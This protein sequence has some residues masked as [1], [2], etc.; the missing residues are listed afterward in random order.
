MFLFSY[1][2]FVGLI[3]LV[4]RSRTFAMRVSR[5]RTFLSILFLLRN[6]PIANRRERR[7]PGHCQFSIVNCQLQRRYFH[8]YIYI[9]TY[10][11]ARHPVSIVK[12]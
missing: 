10:G 12:V 4:V 7:I 2:L 8:L 11:M 1:L 6:T 5:Q 3:I 9:H